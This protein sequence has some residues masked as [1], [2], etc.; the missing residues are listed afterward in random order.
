MHGSQNESG[1]KGE[2]LYELVAGIENVQCPIPHLTFV[3]PLSS[4]CEIA[5]LNSVTG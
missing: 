3:H 2:A 5:S 1:Q 4:V